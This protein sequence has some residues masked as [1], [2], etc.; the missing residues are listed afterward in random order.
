MTTHA[1]LGA[2][3][4][5]GQDRAEQL[6]VLLDRLSQP[7]SVIEDEVPEPQAEVE[8]P[9]QRVL[10][11]RV[12]RRAVDVAVDLLVELHELAGVGRLDSVQPLE[13]VADDLFLTRTDALSGQPRRVALEDDPDLGDAREVRDVDVG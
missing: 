3:P 13:E 10:E 2:L 5:A 8:V 12:S 7:H 9:L 6:D 4:V 1:V 11:K